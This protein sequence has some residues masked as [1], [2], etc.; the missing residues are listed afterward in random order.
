MILKQEVSMVWYLIPGLQLRVWH[1]NL[2]IAYNSITTVISLPINCWQIASVHFFGCFTTT[3]FNLRLFECSLFTICSFFN[4]DHLLLASRVNVFITITLISRICVG[5]T[6]A[7]VCCSLIPI[8]PEDTHSADS[9]YIVV[10]SSQTAVTRCTLFR[11][12]HTAVRALTFVITGQVSYIHLYF[13]LRCCR[14]A[15]YRPVVQTAW[16]HRPNAACLQDAMYS[17]LSRYLSQQLNWSGI[18]G[19]SVATYSMPLFDQL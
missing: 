4:A 18:A 6:R 13:W 12:L 11:M 19:R 3:K 15:N 10:Y 8:P 5:R 7:A 17:K 9:T 2:N 1:T 14:R 16:W